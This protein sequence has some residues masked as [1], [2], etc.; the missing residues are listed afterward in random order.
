MFSWW[1]DYESISFY[2]FVIFS[3]SQIF[4]KVQVFFTLGFYKN[5]KKQSKKLEKCVE[6]KRLT[7]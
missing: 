2:F 6:L 7:L 3:T 5:Q 1:W 4:Y